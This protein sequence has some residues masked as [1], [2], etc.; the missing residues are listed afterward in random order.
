MAG[1]VEKMAGIVEKMAGPDHFHGE[2][3][4]TSPVL[5]ENG[6]H[7]AGFDKNGEVLT[8]FVEKW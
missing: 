7:L 4:S 5:M 3:A 1:L 6:E 8:D 2:T